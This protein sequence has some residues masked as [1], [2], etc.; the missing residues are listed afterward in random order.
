MIR[1]AQI[2]KWFLWFLNPI[3]EEVPEKD[4]GKCNPG[5]HNLS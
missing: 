3:E 5:A 4:I 1:F 2:D